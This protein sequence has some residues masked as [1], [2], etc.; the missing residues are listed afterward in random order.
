MGSKHGLDR[1][2]L[3]TPRGQKKRL[4]VS[5]EISVRGQQHCAL[6]MA[7]DRSKSEGLVVVSLGVS[8]R[9]KQPDTFEM[10]L[11]SSPLERP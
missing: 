1:F 2:G 11:L 7:V 9:Q 10:P 4:R 6:N 5:G 8:H 3:P